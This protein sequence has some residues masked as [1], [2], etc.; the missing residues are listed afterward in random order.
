ML[1][2]M[3]LLF[4]LLVYASALYFQRYIPEH[5][6]KPYIQDDNAM[7]CVNFPKTIVITVTNHLNLLDLYLDINNLQSVYDVLQT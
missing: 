5:K 1:C 7:Q 2:Y 6:Y 3:F 4:T